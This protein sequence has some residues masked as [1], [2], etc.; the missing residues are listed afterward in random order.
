L[1]EPDFALQKMLLCDLGA[2]EAPEGPF[3]DPATTARRAR[4]APAG[5]DLGH[6]MSGA[7]ARGRDQHTA[8]GER[9]PQS[10]IALEQERGT[11]VYARK[12][13]LSC[14]VQSECFY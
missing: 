6:A 2:L 4:N 11:D 5:A 1:D 10:R 7:T 8:R 14:K 13:I 9:A 3:A 12:N